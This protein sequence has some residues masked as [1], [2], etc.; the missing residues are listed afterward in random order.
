MSENEPPRRKLT[1]KEQKLSDDIDHLVEM[2]RDFDRDHAL[3]I[4]RAIRGE[5][6]GDRL[7]RRGTGGFTDMEAYRRKKGKGKSK[8]QKPT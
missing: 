6:M 4:A 3:S 1:P 7:P 2:M 5:R 8:K